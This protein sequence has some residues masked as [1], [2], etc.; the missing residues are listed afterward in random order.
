MKTLN[1]Q[2]FSYDVYQYMCFFIN[3]IQEKKL[4]YVTGGRSAR[5]V[6]KSILNKINFTWYDTWYT[7]MRLPFCYRTVYVSL[8]SVPA[9]F[10]GVVEDGLQKLSM[11]LV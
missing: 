9:K 6:L 4:T 7:K 11:V 3:H 1:K 2:M 10:L 5:V 8:Y